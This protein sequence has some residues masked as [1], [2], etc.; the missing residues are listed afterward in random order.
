MKLINLFLFLFLLGCVSCKSPEENI[1]NESI[2][3]I[4]LPNNYEL[5]PGSF[6]MNGQTTIGIDTSDTAMVAL[7][8][9]FNEKTSDA[10]GFSLPIG[11]SGTILF[12]LGDYKEL[13]E[14]GYQLS[15]SS[16]KLVLSAYRHHG[17]FNGIQSVLQLL[18][19][20]IKSKTVQPQKTW[21]INCVE[22]T[23]KPQFAWR[24]LML[25]VSRH[26]FTKQEV[27]RFI[28]QMAEYKYNVFHW[29]LTDDQGWRLEIKSGSRKPHAESEDRPA[30]PDRPDGT[31][32]FPPSFS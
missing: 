13:G 23:D 28:D 20:E 30:V 9:Y 17:I 16:G 15:V 8:E 27:K 24:G 10:T 11:D 31:R 2:Q 22:I 21:Y 29:H 5:K 18:P 25:D 3:I 19:P 1:P 32:P 7:A 26:F 14:E 4:P 6:C 12:Q